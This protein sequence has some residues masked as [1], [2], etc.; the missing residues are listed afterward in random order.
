MLATLS[1]TFVQILMSKYPLLN[2]KPTIQSRWQ[3]FIIFET[4]MQVSAV[5]STTL[6]SHWQSAQSTGWF[7][8]ALGAKTRLSQIAIGRKWR[9]GL[10]VPVV[11]MTYVTVSYYLS[12][13]HSIPHDAP[14]VRKVVSHD[15]GRELSSSVQQA[16]TTLSHVRRSRMTLFTLSDVDLTR[17]PWGHSS[18]P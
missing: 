16:V 10:I 9:Y 3:K 11:S 1:R 18:T 13:N 8:A 15:Y 17:F 12:G 7:D 5:I 2:C 6:E 14:Y 4:I